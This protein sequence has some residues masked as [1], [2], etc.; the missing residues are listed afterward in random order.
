MFHEH[1]QFKVFH[2]LP[3]EL[4]KTSMRHHRKTMTLT[5]NP[6]RVTRYCL[7]LSPGIVTVLSIFQLK[8]LERTP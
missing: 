5:E 1:D 7:L 2:P 6:T 3:P 8:T 4:L